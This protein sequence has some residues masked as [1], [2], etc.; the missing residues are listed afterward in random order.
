[1]NTTPAA[2]VF[3]KSRVAG[4]Y[5]VAVVTASGVTM[6]IRLEKVETM[7]PS[8][9]G[10]AYMTEWAARLGDH[11]GTGATR[12][13]AVTRLVAAAGRRG[14]ALAFVGE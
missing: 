7:N 9:R 12:T 14:L 11:R 5:T 8:A 6:R 1:M 2:P 13:E 3:T 4:R 10:G